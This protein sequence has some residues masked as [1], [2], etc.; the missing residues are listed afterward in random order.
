MW[1]GVEALAGAQWLSS[2]FHAL[3]VPW[4][5]P[6][7]TSFPLFGSQSKQST[8]H[9]LRIVTFLPL[10]DGVSFALDIRTVPSREELATLSPSGENR[11]HVMGAS[12]PPNVE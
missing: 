2:T 3:T 8:S 11:Q 9:A 6:K 5:V 1:G 4:D 10:D 7:S 12:W